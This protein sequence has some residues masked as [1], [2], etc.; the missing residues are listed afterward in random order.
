MDLSVN[1][2]PTNQPLITGASSENWE[3]PIPRH[4]QCQGNCDK[5]PKQ[6]ICEKLPPLIPL[7]LDLSNY[8]RTILSFEKQINSIKPSY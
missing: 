7:K 5:C 2:S 8:I 6:K 1:E 3:T 4:Q